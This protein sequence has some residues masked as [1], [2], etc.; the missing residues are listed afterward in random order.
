MIR[1]NPPLIK[2]TDQEL[3][4]QFERGTLPGE[5]FRHREH[6][7]VAFLYLT[8]YPLLEV[9][10]AFSAALRKFAATHGKPRLYHE[11]ITWSYIFLIRERM[12]RAGKNQSWEEFAWNNSDLLVWKGGLLSRYYRQETLESDLARAIF[13]LPDR[14]P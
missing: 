13:V 5:C 11:T 4:E 2:M 10:A 1:D 8:R 7:R 6:L 3:L 12:V 9:L 14:C